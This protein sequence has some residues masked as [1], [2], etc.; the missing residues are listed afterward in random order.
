[1]PPLRAF[2]VDQRSRRPSAR[3]CPGRCRAGAAPRLASPRAAAARRG[4]RVTHVA[5]RARRG[6]VQCSSRLC[7]ASSTVADMV[8]SLSS[9]SPDRGPARPGTGLAT[10]ASSGAGSDGRGPQRDGVGGIP[11]VVAEQC[12][13]NAGAGTDVGHHD[14]RRVGHSPRSAARPAPPPGRPRAR[15]LRGSSPR[16]RSVKR[17][18]ITLV[19]ASRATARAPA[20]PPSASLPPSGSGV[21]EPDA[22]EQGACVVQLVSHPEVLPRRGEHQY[23]TGHFRPR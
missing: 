4:V 23:R 22:R 17:L 11:G 10:R 6:A 5:G 3:C 2:E 15:R 9:S 19:R 14:D 7:A 20:T 16:R 1:M 8:D 12:G 21:V 18:T 13:G